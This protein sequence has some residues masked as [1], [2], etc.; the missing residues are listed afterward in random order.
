[1]Q[2]WSTSPSALED[3]AK[4]RAEMSSV[5]PCFGQP[6]K[7]RSDHLNW[8]LRGTS[9]PGFKSDL[10]LADLWRGSGGPFPDNPSV[11]RAENTGSESAVPCPRWVYS[12]YFGA[13]HLFGLT[14]AVLLW[15]YLLWC[16]SLSPDLVYFH[17][18]GLFFFVP[19]SLL[20]LRVTALCLFLQHARQTA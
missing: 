16:S 15:F 12:V 1:M 13:P 11:H 19:L 2:T 4:A 9:S 7:P 3:P 8:K 14:V 18:N 10:P 20:T 5:L 6:L 17:G